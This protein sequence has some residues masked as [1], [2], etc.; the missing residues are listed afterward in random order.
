[1]KVL[2]VHNY[3]GQWG[4]VDAA[5]RSD[6]ASLRR[7]GHAVAEYVRHSSEI[8][9]AW[10]RI[11]AA[12]R[13]FR[14]PRTALDIA[15][16]AASGVDVAHVHNILPLI[17]PGVYAEL[18]RRGI[19]VVQT[20]HD[21]RMM[22]VNGIFFTQGEVCRRC[23]GGNFLHAIPRTC[24][25]KGV[26]ATILYAAV[27]QYARATRAFTRGIDVFVAVSDF[28]RSQLRELGIPPSRIVVRGNFEDPPVAPSFEPGTYGLYLGRLAREKG[29]WTLLKALDR[30][31]E[32]RF[33]IAG[34][35][36]EEE[37]LKTFARDRGM[38][39]VEFLGFVPGKERFEQ[40]RGASVLV[41][42]SECHESYGISAREAL[43][44]GTPVIASRMGGLPELVIPGVTGRL[45]RA[46]DDQ[47]LE[48]ALASMEREAPAMRRPARA[49]FERSYSA[50]KGTEALMRAYALARAHRVS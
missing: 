3:F 50:D 20:V 9:G 37:K 39:H 22:C 1:M 35:G 13:V 24:H 27:L 7:S 45:V 49:Q 17:G 5:V 33:R 38:T 42:P 23:A 4:G 28:V 21:Y 8:D 32:A 15:R 40:L 31:R 25:P 47:D 44:V 2:V 10:S 18:R 16:L 11:V 6:I 29:I 48:A 34:T 46:G 41:I 36:P 19:P 14:S 12:A 30:R 26:A 43:S